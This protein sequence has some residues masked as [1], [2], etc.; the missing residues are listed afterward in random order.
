M[1][2][3]TKDT[4]ENANLEEVKQ[5]VIRK[6][7]TSPKKEAK[8]KKVEKEVSLSDTKTAKVSK[9]KKD[10]V[11]SRSTTKKSASLE[12]KKTVASELEKKETKKSATKSKSTKA[13]I[14]TKSSSKTSTKAPKTTKA[15]TKATNKKVTEKK[16]TSKSSKTTS[17]NKKAE[18]K[19]IEI[20]EYYD[21]PYRYN[22][23]VVK[24]L[25]QTPS[26]LFIYWDISDE[27]RKHYIDTYGEYFFHNTKPVLI[28]HNLTMHY[29]FEVDINDFAN[30]WYLQ[31][32]DSKC[33]YQIEL[34]RRP[35]NQYVTIPNSYLY[36]SSSNPIESPNDHILI[37]SLKKNLLFRNIKTNQVIEKDISSIPIFEKIS[38]LLPIQDLYK[39]LYGDE[40]LTFDRF[41]FRN[42][43]SGNPTSTFK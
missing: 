13:K 18:T 9:A 28:L 8:S 1:P 34:G 32:Q 27:D 11:I 6:K 41:D 16:N 15:T 25:A 40:L 23:T 35:I 21:L 43:S 38:K 22:Q 26:T 12:N 19:K 24:V 30:S 42:P 4:I 14:A 17:K 10:S 7:T 20:L 39:K 31:V 2:R 37:H 3:K 29:S 5:E 36:I 33:D